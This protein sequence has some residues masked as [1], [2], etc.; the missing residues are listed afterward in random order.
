M[1]KI[2]IL[3]FLC[4][5]S[6]VFAQKA[7]VNWEC[8]PISQIELDNISVLSKCYGYV[9]FFYPNQLTKNF[10]WTK[11]LM[12]SVSK[13]E[14]I[15]NDD[16]L[17]QTLLELFQ[18]ICPQI[19]FSTDSMIVRKKLL[20]PYF[21]MEYHAIGT[22][23]E[24]MYGKNHSP[25]IQVMND[26]D[27]A[28]T[29][30][31]KLKENLYVNFPV[32]VKVLS[33]KTKEFT[34]LKKTIDKID[35]GKI[36][37]VSALLDKE[38]MKK[39]NL[40]FKQQT[41]RI[42][43]VMIRRNYI[44]HFYPYF[45][46]DGLSEIWDRECMKTIEKMATVNNLNDYYAEICKLLAN[47]KDSHVNIWNTFHVGS[48]ATYTPHF[49]PDIFLDFANDTWFVNFVGKEYQNQIKQGDRVLSINKTQI[50]NVLRK[51]LLEIPYSTKPNGWHKLA[52]SGKLLE[53]AKKD[54][55]FEITVKSSDNIEKKI[56]VKAHLDDVP[57]PK[58]NSFF[59]SMNNRIVYVNMCSDSCTYANFV[60]K[61]PLI[62]NSKGIIFDMRGYPQYEVLSII[63]HFI[64]EK[65]ELG[66]LLSPIIRFPN[67][68]NVQYEM[69]E[70]WYVLPATSPQSKA[71]S[72]KNQYKEPVF[73]QIEKPIVF[74]INEK[75]ISFGETFAEM[76]KF[77]KVGTLVG[78]HTSGCNG[79]A[80]FLSMPGATFSMTYNKFFNRDGSQHHGIGILPDI[81]CEAQ[82][83]DIQTGIDTQL[84]KAKELLQ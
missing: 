10:N 31:Y 69:A 77:Y 57:Q 82:L 55:V 29:Y 28:D 73:I 6:C 63:S 81:N 35:E 80:T 58:T 18:P 68:E 38:K 65:I 45:S 70:K 14:K 64:K 30:C 20:P 11:F 62:Q 33:A 53:C 21:V 5:S 19:S 40:I 66:K 44:Q 48:V 37:I 76:M 74:L 60:K 78:T 54:S 50:E 3:L 39:S 71:S 61:I 26:R 56:Q 42:A 4:F 17:K 34:Q 46:E 8:K 12:Y 25:I 27:Y 72:K 22:L 7:V 36:N 75:T 15:D 23:A 13:L 83:S 16:E 9:R 49:Y 79:D 52:Y 24:I 1:K 67:Q 2:L 51:K 41:Y 84:E 47:V 59:Q 43:D 32:A